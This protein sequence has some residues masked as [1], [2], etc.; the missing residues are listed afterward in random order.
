M[1]EHKQFG[2]LTCKKNSD[3]AILPTSMSCMVMCC[4][5]RMRMVILSSGGLGFRQD[6]EWHGWQRHVDDGSCGGTHC[7]EY[8]DDI[9]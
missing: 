4:R 9:L 8:V 3:I 1:M 5:C 6:D 7:V 2:E